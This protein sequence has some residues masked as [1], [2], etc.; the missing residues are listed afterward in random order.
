MG[1]GW[2]ARLELGR[3]S[4]ELKFYLPVAALLL[5]AGATAQRPIWSAL[6]IIAVG[7]GLI[8]WVAGTTRPH[9][10]RG[11][12]AQALGIALSVSAVTYVAIYACDLGSMV[13]ETLRHGPDR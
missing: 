5:A 2:R 10:L 3:I 1:I 8:V 13:A 6:A 9:S 7:G 11:L 4:I 12:L